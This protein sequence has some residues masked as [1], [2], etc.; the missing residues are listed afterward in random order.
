MQ[1]IKIK[2]G[3][4]GKQMH[5]AEHAVIPAP[6][7]LWN[8]DF[9]YEGSSLPDSKARVSCCLCMMAHDLQTGAT[10]SQT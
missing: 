6:Q 8:P 5:Y 7:G 1:C 9:K 4:Q 2:S 10:A 3:C